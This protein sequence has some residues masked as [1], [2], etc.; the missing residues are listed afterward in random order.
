M[1]LTIRSIY[2]CHL[3]NIAT[4]SCSYNFSLINAYSHAAVSHNVDEFE[5]TKDL[6]EAKEQIKRKTRRYPNVSFYYYYKK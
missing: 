2:F 6:S 5:E 4:P 3:K 1:S